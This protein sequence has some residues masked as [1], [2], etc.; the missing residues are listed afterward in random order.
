MSAVQQIVELLRESIKDGRIVAG[1][2]LVENDLTREYGVSR[3]PLREA[4]AHLAAE[5]LIE[6]A[7]H[8][9]ALVRKLDRSEIADLFGM[10]EVLEG[11]GARLAA[12]NIDH[13]T[14]RARFEEAW[15]RI[16]ETAAGG[17]PVAYVDENEHFHDLI[18]DLAGNQL[19]V[20]HVE[21]LRLQVFRLQFRRSMNSPSRERSMADHTD[22]AAAILAGDERAAELAM[23]AHVRKGAVE[24]DRLIGP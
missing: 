6:I 17:D 18:V 15:A 20:R 12:R 22:V 4:F 11:E 9:G 5:G 16:Q 24:I 2:R 1:Q 3:G 23:R 14:N 8:R 10:R 19:L 7:P 21:M 13:G